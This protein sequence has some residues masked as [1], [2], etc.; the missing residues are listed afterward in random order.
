L[1]C[2]HGLLSPSLLDPFLF[3]GTIRYNLD[4]FEE[5]EKDDIVEALKKSNLLSTFGEQQT[6]D[7]TD[8]DRD[9]RSGSKQEL[10]GGVADWKVSKMLDFGVT[11]LSTGQK[12]LICLARCILRHTKLVLVDEATSSLDPQAEANLFKSLIAS[13]PWSTSVIIICHNPD[14][15]TPFCNIIIELEKGSV[16][17]Y[18]QRDIIL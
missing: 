15:V 7:T 18:E 10:G 17:R 2:Y 12:Q 3:A 6:W 4:P 5:F 13:I 1:C 8:V 16:K 9:S 14:A 11:D